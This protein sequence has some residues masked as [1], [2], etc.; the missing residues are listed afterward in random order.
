MLITKDDLLFDVAGVAGCTMKF[1]FIF[2]PAGVI[3]L[4]QIL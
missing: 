1:L 3:H 2:N 4:K